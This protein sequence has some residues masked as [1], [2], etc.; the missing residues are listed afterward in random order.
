MLGFGDGWHE[1]EYAPAQGLSW[2]WASGKAVLRTSAADRDVE[3]QIIGESPRRYFDRSSRVAAT[4]GATALWN[5]DVADDFAWSF[6]IPASALKAS[7]GTITIE[8]DQFYRP[9]DRGQ[10]ADRRALGLRIYSVKLK[11][12]S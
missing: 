11:P 6:R 1:P 9:A 10:G 4:A 3:L 7:N 5:R 2:R 12:A 8:T